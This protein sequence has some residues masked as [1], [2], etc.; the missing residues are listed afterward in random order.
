MTDFLGNKLNVNDKVVFVP[1]G[2][3]LF[4]IGRIDKFTTNFVFVEETSYGVKGIIRQLPSQL[5]RVPDEK[6]NL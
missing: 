1:M 5:I 2:K 3:R 4:K 6:D